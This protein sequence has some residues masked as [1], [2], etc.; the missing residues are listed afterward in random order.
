MK[1]FL[2]MGA[3]LVACLGLPGLAFAQTN[4]PDKPTWWAK[5]QSLLRNGA[6]PDGHPSASLQVGTNV[7]VSSECGPQSE[8]FIT[9]NPTRTKTLVG[10]SNEIFR[11]PM[12]GYFSSDGGRTWG[13][14]DLPLPPAIGGSNSFRFG[15]D[16]TLAFD[17]Q[18][19][20]FY[21]YIV[22][23]F[24]NVK[25]SAVDGTELAVARSSDG[26]KTYPQGTF[27]SFESGS[28][29]FND[30]PMITADAN[31][32]NPFRHTGYIAWDAA[33]GGSTGGGIRVGRWMDHGAS[34]SVTRADN[35]SGRGQ[36]IGAVPFVGPNGEL[37]I[38]WNDFVNN[39]IAFNRSFDGGVTFGQQ[40]TI[41]P[42]VIPFDI[43]IPAES[44]R[45]ALVYPACGADRSNGPH[46]GRL[47]CSWVDLSA[48][49]VTDIFISFSDDRGSTW[50]PPQPVT[51]QLSFPVD[52]FNQWL[53]VDPVTGDVNVSFYDTRN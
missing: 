33:A 27:F 20:V 45:G 19:N 26:G 16:P 29:H 8:T 36:S 49:S 3:L 39:V 51:D 13:G 17:T 43:A 24:S 40:I 38:A 2:R 22:V 50:S 37:Y 6:S 32:N 25:N 42:K 34:F 1:R 4:T 48:G 47:Y 23:F 46:R 5:L 11:L 7:D 21:G 18:G 28:N 52:R 9:L 15:S 41:A 31:L 53:S 35:P 14:V 44:F 10:G 12:R 30:K